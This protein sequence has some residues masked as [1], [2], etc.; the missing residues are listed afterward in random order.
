M[1][2]GGCAGTA[3]HPGPGYFQ[4]NRSYTDDSLGISLGDADRQYANRAP[5]PTTTGPT[6][7]P[8]VVRGQQPTQQDLYNRAWNESAPT[9]RN[10]YEPM[11]GGTN[12][13]RQPMPAYGVTNAG[14]AA[15]SSY[16]NSS[17]SPAAYEFSAPPTP[18]VSPRYN[19]YQAGP[20]QGGVSYSQP[21]PAQ[22][23]YQQQPV[24]QQPT[25]QQQPG[26][27]GAPAQGAPVEQLPPPQ[28][29]TPNP[30]PVFSPGGQPFYPPSVVAES[31]L[32]RP[33][34]TP[35]DLNVRV[36]ETRTGRFMF[37]VG[38]N[39]DAG[40]TGQIVI[41][42]RNFN[43][44]RIPTS[45]QDWVNGTA[46]RG[47]GQGFRVEALPGSQV[48]RYLVNFT[49]PYLF[50][51]RISFNV[52]GYYY[53][54]Y[55]YDW[56]EQR[57]GGR[58]GLG[59][60]LA[61]DLSV[62]AALRMEN[63]NLS[64]PRV[65]TVQE[66]NEALG[67]TSLYTGRFTVSHDTRDSSFAPTEGYLLEL[68][69]EQGFGT[70]VYPRGEIDYRRY[71]LLRERPDGSGRHT[72]AY[73]F[74]FGFSGP[75]TPIYENYF[76]GGYSSLR[77][78]KFRGASPEVN[79]VQVGGEFRFLGSAEY[80]FP[81]TADDM[82]KGVL[83]VDYGTTERDISID[84]NNFRVAPGF[85]LRISVPAMGPAP[86]ALDFAFPVIDAETDNRQVFSFFV[87]FGR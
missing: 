4:S 56:N 43:I 16:D 34:G 81:L 19:T 49:E 47:A 41:D 53:E 2:M 7:E 52:S 39:S 23:T 75:D 33:E 8:L 77:G 65:N 46:F 86:I 42:E 60:N 3:S 79:G 78:F 72:L 27:P 83:F 76:S 31:E 87:G 64:N 29:Y 20:T 71:F 68:A 44:A 69:Y 13:M 63:V 25:Y 74:R 12:A 26:Y 66:L 73:N 22:P 70:F 84:P 38:V 54:R 28:I 62:N 1:A 30:N 24:Y 9:N 51:T 15:A 6:Q 59:Y 45:Y 18:S 55:F 48:Q 17:V 11:P 50:D 35:V 85:G 40:L 82:M 5:V 36:D 10:G 61:P 67:D 21:A 14:G 37:G 58:V 32:L 80:M 57:L